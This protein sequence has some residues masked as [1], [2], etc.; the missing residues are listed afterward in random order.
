MWNPSAPSI[1]LVLIWFAEFSSMLEGY[2]NV[3][4]YCYNCKFV[5]IGDQEH[6]VALLIWTP[7]D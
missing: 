6:L 5:R 3:R 2:E 4:A 1:L 7:A